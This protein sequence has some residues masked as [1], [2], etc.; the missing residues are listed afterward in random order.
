[1]LA[2]IASNFTRESANLISPSG[3]NN[4]KIAAEPA[5]FNRESPSGTNALPT[6]ANFP[7]SISDN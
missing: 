6:S 5:I 7:G 3:P 1:L 4:F 2:S